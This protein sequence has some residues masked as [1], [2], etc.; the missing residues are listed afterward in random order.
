VNQHPHWYL[1]LLEG[2][3]VLVAKLNPRNVR[4][5]AKL[6]PRNFRFIAKLNPRNVRFILRD[7]DLVQ[8]WILHAYRN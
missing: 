8:A 6:N 1:H 4:F 7:P 5:I 2:G 3:L